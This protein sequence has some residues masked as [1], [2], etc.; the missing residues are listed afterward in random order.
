VYFSFVTST[1]DRNLL[2]IRIVTEQRS[3]FLI[4]TTVFSDV[5]RKG[6][7]TKFREMDLLPM[8]DLGLSRWLIFKSRSSGLS[9]LKKAAAWTSET[10]V[11]FLTLHGV[12]T[13][14]TLI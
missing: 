5:L 11:S 8:R 6:E 12:T 1:S 7:N 4:K 14:I 2:K 9:L 3:Q 13:Q 10:T